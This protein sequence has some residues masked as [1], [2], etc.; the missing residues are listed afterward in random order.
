MPNKKLIRTCIGCRAKRQKQDM[1]RIVKNKQNEIKPDFKQNLEGRGAYICKE[2]SC[3]QK[4]EKNNS[5]RRALKTNIENKKY[6][7]L[8]GVV[9][10][11]TSG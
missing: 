8:R 7:E 5:L 3:F 4:A 10:D 2:E 11:R 1:I 9:F 6:E